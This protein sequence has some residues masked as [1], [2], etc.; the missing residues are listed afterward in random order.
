MLC[1]NA[2]GAPNPAVC[3]GAAVGAPNAGAAAGVPKAGGA[4]VVGAL[5]VKFPNAAKVIS[6]CRISEEKKENNAHN[7]KSKG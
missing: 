7:Q 3:C 1:P 4:D 6:K 2:D 5:N